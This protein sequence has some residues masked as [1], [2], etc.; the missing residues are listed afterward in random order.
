MAAVGVAEVGAES[1]NFDEAGMRGGNFF[2]RREIRLGNQDDAEL[3]ADSVG[4]G[5]DAHNFVGCGAGGDVV[6]GRLAMKE[7]IADATSGEI[8]QMALV[9]Q[10]A[11]DRDGEGRKHRI[12]NTAVSYQL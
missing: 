8:G 3:G 4:L 12:D 11:E 1:G 6:V 7:E 10:G 5:E 9:A 2:G